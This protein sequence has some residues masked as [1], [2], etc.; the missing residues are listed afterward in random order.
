MRVVAVTSAL[1]FSRDDNPLG[2]ALTVG[3]P[4]PDRGNF[5]VPIVIKVPFSRL[6]LLPEGT[7]VRGRLVFYFVVVDSEGK[8]SELTTQPVPVTVR[9]FRQPKKNIPQTKPERDRILGL[10]REY[11]E[12]NKLV[13]PMPLD[14]LRTH[15]ERIL[16]DHQI[17]AIHLDYVG[18]LIGNEAWRE[19]LATIP[20]EK[21][22]L[23]MPKCLRVESKCPAPFDEFGLLRQCAQEI[24]RVGMIRNDRQNLPV[25]RLGF[26]QVA[27][28]VVFQRQLQSLGNSHRSH[29]GSLRRHKDPSIS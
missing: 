6:A 11:V 27:G 23:L 17:D 10:V 24:Q 29:C 15:A 18:V 12:T 22:L 3:D 28:A 5:I 4:V 13:P 9:R 1:F 20:Y 21:R 2:A 25:N 19:T 16:A 8:Q 26:L 7:K 14:E